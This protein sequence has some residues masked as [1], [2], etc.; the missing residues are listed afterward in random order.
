MRPAAIL[1]FDN[2]YLRGRL[3]LTTTRQL[4][5]YTSSR[6]LATTTTS[7]LNLFIYLLLWLIIIRPIVRATMDAAAA[8]PAV[9]MGQNAFL[10]L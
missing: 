8:G 1:I 9:L 10:I 3:R 2:V 6:A 5:A 7:S 4:S